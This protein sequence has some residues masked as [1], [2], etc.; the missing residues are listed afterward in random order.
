MTKYRSRLWLALCL[1]LI[2][3]FIGFRIWRLGFPTET[4][5]DEVYFPKMASQYLGGE[6]FFDIHPPL[7]KLIIAMGEILFGNT[8]IGWRVM[9]LLAG[10]GILPAGYWSMK[11][12]FGSENGKLAGLLAALLLA[13]D[14]LL[15]VYSRT[16]L[17]DGFI[18]LFG[19]LSV[20]FCWQFIRAREKGE[21]AVAPMLWTGIFAGLAL[22]VKWI[23]AGFLPLVA[24]AILL[25]MFFQKKR[26]IDF[27]DFQ[28][29]FVAFIIIPFV[30]Y[31]L[32]FLAN[33]QTDF[34]NQFALWH[35]QSWDY[36]IHL[37]AT[38]PYSSKWWSWP[39]LVRPIW[40][41][42]KGDNGSVIGVDGIGNPLEWWAS[43][44]AVVY[45]IL[46]VLYTSL[47]FKRQENQILTAHQLWPVVFLL[48]G[49]G[50]FFLPWSVIGRVLFLYHYLTSYVFALLLM[51]FWLATLWQE[52]WNRIALIVIIA[53]LVLSA[54]VFLPIW[55]A[56]PVPQEYFNRLMLF[57]S[58]I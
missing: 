35:H 12:L 45:S 46:A 48:A 57:K 51:A 50:I 16:G 17:M 52:R 58:W 10:I 8:P 26:P 42:Y 27:T 23:G 41:Y 4:V 56:Y 38:H 47:T 53:L 54:L 9:P 6:Q 5:F 18:L 37:D 31:T 33:W 32:P 14:G 34:W 15:I 29:W 49:W 20:G 43:T 13:I 40:F 19:I 7:G 1:G 11:Q 24:G 55:I 2:V 28:L 39:F 25:A 3:L 21:R 22:A 44:L 30:L 36:N